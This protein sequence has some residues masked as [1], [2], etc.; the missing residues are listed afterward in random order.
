MVE[1][2]MDKSLVRHDT[3]ARSCHCFTNPA[4]RSGWRCP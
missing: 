4:R 1:Y 3:V 2:L